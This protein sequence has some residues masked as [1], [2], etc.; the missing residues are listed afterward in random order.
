MQTSCHR[1]THAH[2]TRVSL[3]N[4]F[5]LEIRVSFLINF[6]RVYGLGS[7]NEKIKIK[8]KYYAKIII[9][10]KQT[11]LLSFLFMGNERE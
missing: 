8:L 2:Q 1:K 10:Q 4:T 7:W 3:I 11:K 5:E 9:T 6:L